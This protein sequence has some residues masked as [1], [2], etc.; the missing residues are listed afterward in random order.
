MEDKYYTIEEVSVLLR[1][2]IRTVY[3]WIKQGNLKAIQ[4]MNGGGYRI[5]KT[6]IDR[7]YASNLA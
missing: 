7:Y 6:E 2:S 3:R 5:P 4:I 1:V